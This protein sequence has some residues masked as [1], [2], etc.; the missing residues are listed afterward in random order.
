MVGFYKHDIPAW[1]DGTEGLGDGAYRAYHVI[2]QLIMLNEGPIARNERGIAGR[3]NQPLRSF[4]KNLNELLTAGKLVIDEQGRIANERAANELDSV[5]AN[6]VNAGKGGIISGKVRKTS[7]KFQITS[8]KSGVTSVFPG[9]TSD[10]SAADSA[11][12]LKNN[13]SG[14]ATLPEG[15][16]LKEKRREEKRRVE[17]DAGETIELPP[18]PW[19]VA[20]ADQAAPAAPASTPTGY[21]FEAGIIKLNDTDFERWRR[22]YPNINLAGELTA[23]AD[24]ASRLKAEGKNWFTVIPNQLIKLERTAKREREESR[25]A[26]EARAKQGA[27][28]APGRPAI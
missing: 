14:E 16:S 17:E 12:P 11:N 4:S 7:G 21:A 2:V 3:C 22:A 5:L 13:D 25:M 27:R 10:K 15:R 20:P 18:L 8:E 23:M 1:M 26:V 28:S 24:W 6:R 19:E 9:V